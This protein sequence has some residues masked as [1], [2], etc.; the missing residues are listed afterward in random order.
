VGGWGRSWARGLHL[1]MAS[2]SQRQI[3][4][5]YWF[6]SGWCATKTTQKAFGQL[7]K[8]IHPFTTGSL[9]ARPF[10]RPNTAIQAFHTFQK[11]HQPRIYS[12][13]NAEHLH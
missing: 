12:L 4:V 9:D 6:F 5:L 2:E 11:K 1:K 7:Y 3:I 10:R 13:S 8:T